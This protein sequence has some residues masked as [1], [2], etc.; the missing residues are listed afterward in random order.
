MFGYG[1]LLNNSLGDQ[2]SGVWYDFTHLLSDVPFYWYIIALALLA[3]L[4]KLLTRR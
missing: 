3:F 1:A 2:L 4:T